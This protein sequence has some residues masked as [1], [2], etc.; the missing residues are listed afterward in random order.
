MDIDLAVQYESDIGPTEDD[1]QCVLSF[2]DSIP[3]GS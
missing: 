1:C 2:P 3:I